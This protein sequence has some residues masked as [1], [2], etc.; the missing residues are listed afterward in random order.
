MTWERTLG[1]SVLF[2]VLG[3][4][5]GNDES[6]AP[7]PPLY[8]GQPPVQG[9]PAHVVGG[10]T[11]TIPEQTLDPGAEEFPCWIFPVAIDGDS[12]LIGGAH[13]TTG[14]GLHHGNLTA[15]PKTGEGVREC[16]MTDRAGGAEALDI[17]NGGTWVFASS[18]Q[19]EGEEWQSFPA[20]Y[21]YRVRDDW[22]IVA[23]MHYLNTTAD[24]VAVAPTYEW[25]TI[26]E[27]TVVHV[28][29][30]FG[31]IYGGF[32]IPPLSPYTVTGNCYHPAL[33]PAGFQILQLM[34]HM[35]ALG[36]AFTA[37]FLGGDHAGEKF[38]D[39]PGYDPDRGVVVQYQPVVDLGLAEGITF[40]C[41][42]NNTYDQEIVEGVGKNEM[43]MLF[44]YGYD[45]PYFGQAASSEVCAVVAVPTE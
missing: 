32:H 13:L 15:R 26:D 20:G 44:G 16:S 24:A 10:M 14:P 17:V 4:G 43:C 38:L 3:G 33:L 8:R 23:R 18:T 31:F 19:I 12:R 45:T 35:H 30:P 37:S 9:E 22:E 42:W 39:S 2:A 29:Y 6:E 5:C 25:F 1:A 27:S 36:T 40:S 34:P 41:T 28:L 11:I 21:G 7:L